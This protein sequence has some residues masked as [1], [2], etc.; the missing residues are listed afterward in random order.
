MSHLTDKELLRQGRYLE[1]LWDNY[2]SYP[3]YVMLFEGT[4][5][6]IN[7]WNTTDYSYGYNKQVCVDSNHP[8]GR[9]FGHCI[10]HLKDAKAKDINFS[11]VSTAKKWIKKNTKPLPEN[12]WWCFGNHNADWL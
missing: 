5:K 6:Y 11:S 3:I 10:D 1:A 4:Q 7:V 8:T 9:W 12:Q 2:N